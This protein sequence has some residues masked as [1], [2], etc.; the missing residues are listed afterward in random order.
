LTIKTIQLNKK[1][2]PDY[3]YFTIFYPF[4][5]TTLYD[6]CV[7]LDLIDNERM[8]KTRQYYE[9]SVLKNVF[10]KE[11]CTRITR[12]LNSVL[13]FEKKFDLHVSKKGCWYYSLMK[14]KFRGIDLAKKTLKILFG[15]RIIARIRSIRNMKLP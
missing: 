9:E 7:T 5:G 3:A 1:V 6:R 2:K 4:P 15:K 11:Y 8:E 12:K 10:L 14:M 13:P